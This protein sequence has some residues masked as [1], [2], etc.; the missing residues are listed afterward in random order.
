MG[1][2]GGGRLRPDPSSARPGAPLR[3]RGAHAPRWLCGSARM[4]HVVFQHG[5]ISLLAACL[6]KLPYNFQRRMSRLEQR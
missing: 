2:R 4:N 1:Q 5:V 6:S 3:Q